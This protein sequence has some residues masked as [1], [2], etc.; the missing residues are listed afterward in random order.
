MTDKDTDSDGNATVVVKGSMQDANDAKRDI[1]ALVSSSSNWNSD[2][3]GGG[4]G[5]S[6]QFDRSDNSRNYDSRNDSSRNFERRNDGSRNNDSRSNDNKDTY[7]IYPDKVGLVI[8][9]AGATIRDIQDKF[10][11]RVNI[12]KNENHNGKA[13]V[14]VSGSQNDVTKAIDKIKELVGESNAYGSQQNG[15]GS[16]S[17]PQQNK[18]ELERMEYEP[19]DWQAAARESVSHFI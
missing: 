12:D 4:G 7:E 2:R 16:Q 14:T 19:I 6:R 18:S 1:M 17:Q 13:V 10:K 8:G 3:S 5:G 11:V 15:F 9:R